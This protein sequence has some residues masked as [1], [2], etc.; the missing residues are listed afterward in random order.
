M[1][2]TLHALCLM[3]LAVQWWRWWWWGVGCRANAGC[4]R[5]QEQNPI[6]QGGDDQGPDGKLKFWTGKPLEL[7]AQSPL[8]FRQTVHL[9]YLSVASWY[10]RCSYLCTDP[11]TD[12]TLRQ[13]PVAQTERVG[14][15]LTRWVHE[16][17]ASWTPGPVRPR[18]LLDPII[19]LS[20]QQIS[21]NYLGQSLLGRGY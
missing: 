14:Q 4:C 17:Q 10:D 16:A 12:Q 18:L 5:P 3:E 2:R 11:L 21:R 15:P 9:A 8:S 6:C 1:N 19:S 20:C 13:E 7:Q